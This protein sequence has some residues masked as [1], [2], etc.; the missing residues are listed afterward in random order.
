MEDVFRIDALPCRVDGNPP[1][2]LQWYHEGAEIQASVPLT[3]TGSG[4]YTAEAVNSLGKDSTSVYVT[5]ECEFIF[6]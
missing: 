1:A 2:T 6:T 4:Q 3:R 5:V